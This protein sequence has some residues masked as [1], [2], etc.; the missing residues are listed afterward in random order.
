MTKVITHFGCQCAYMHSSAVL[1]LLEP[2]MGIGWVL[3][4]HEL[5]TTYV[6]EDNRLYIRSYSLFTGQYTIYKIVDIH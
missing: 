5:C 4:R 1:G 2:F 6:M 3:I